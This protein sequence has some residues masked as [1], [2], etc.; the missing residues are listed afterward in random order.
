MEQGAGGMTRQIR[1]LAAFPGDLGS[2]PRIYLVTHSTLVPEEAD[3]FLPVSTST[4]HMH[5]HI[6]RQNIHIHRIETG[7]KKKKEGEDE[8]KEEEGGRGGR[9][10]GGGDRTYCLLYQTADEHQDD[11]KSIRRACNPW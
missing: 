10:R 8:R 2:V 5:R 7:R 1:E 6:C 11:L 9:R 3:T 4:A